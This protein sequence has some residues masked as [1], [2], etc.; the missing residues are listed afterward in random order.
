MVEVTKMFLQCMLYQNVGHTIS[1]MGV[2][3]CDSMCIYMHLSYYYLNT[4]SAVDNY[5]HAQEPGY[6]AGIIPSNN[7]HF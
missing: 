5:D 6:E 2:C 4:C 7:F 1:Y 3:I